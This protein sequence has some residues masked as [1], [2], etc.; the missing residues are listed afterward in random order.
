MMLLHRSPV[1]L[2]LAVWSALPA[3]H[4]AETVPPVGLTHTEHR[5]ITAA[6]TGR[7][8]E[9]MVSLPENSPPMSRSLP[10]LYVLDGW[11]FP[12]MAFLQNNNQYSERMGPVII[13][14]IGQVPAADA[15]KE[16]T[17][18]FTPTP[19]P[20]WPGSGHAAEFLDFLE[21]ELMPFIERTYH[22]SPTDR[23]LL[24]HSLGGLFALYALEERPGLFRRIMS[25][26]PVAGWDHDLLIKTAAEKLKSLPGTVRLDLSAG[27]EGDL[28]KSL[29]AQTADFA[30]KLD[31]LKPANLDYRFT[32]YPGENHNSVRLASFPRGLYWLY[33]P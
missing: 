25:A 6:K 16:R 8:Y 22:T 5:T 30:R 14:S 19:Q 1:L 33:R 29:G 26:S 28:E 11:H 20:D 17:V 4:G 21:H 18:D 15:M 27:D 2:A 12:L 13:V 9:L 3:L 7:H 31:A 10:V 23:A 32:V 24:G